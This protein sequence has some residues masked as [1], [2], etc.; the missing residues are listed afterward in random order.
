VFFVE[1]DH[2]MYLKLLA[3]QCRRHG[4]SLLGD[5]LMTNHVHLIAVPPRA[6]SLAKAIGRTHWLYTQYVNRL[7]GRS[8]H[9]WQNRF[10]SCAT[11]DEH[12]LLAARYAEKNPIRAG[13]CRIA[14]RWKWSSAAA[15]C[16]GRDELSIL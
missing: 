7:H 6:D 5:C 1:D 16:C 3:A 11:D 10:Y 13:L 2:R 15:H 12:T 8:G 9:L 14:R 4:V